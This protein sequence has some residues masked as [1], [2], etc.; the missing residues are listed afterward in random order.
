MG[1]G[2]SNARHNLQ[3]YAR[4]SELGILPYYLPKVLQHYLYPRRVLADATP[5]DVTEILC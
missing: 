1:T 3:G 4:P 2:V 5:G